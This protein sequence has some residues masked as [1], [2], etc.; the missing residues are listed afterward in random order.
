[1][2]RLLA[3]LDLLLGLAF[4]SFFLAFFLRL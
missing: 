3:F 1:M 4:L 2:D